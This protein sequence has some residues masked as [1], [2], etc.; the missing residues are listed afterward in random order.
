V[1]IQLV[2]N[3]DFFG[4]LL[5]FGRNLIVTIRGWNLVRDFTLNGQMGLF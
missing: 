4:W 3:F 2:R 1:T 5:G